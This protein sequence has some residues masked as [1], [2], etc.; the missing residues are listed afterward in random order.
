MQAGTTNLRK[1]AKP[2]LFLTTHL[3]VG[4]LRVGADARIEF[5]KFLCQ[6]SARI[7]Q[8]AVKQMRRVPKR[9]KMMMMTVARLNFAASGG[10]GGGGGRA[11]A[12]NKA[13]SA[14]ELTRS[15]VTL[16][17]CEQLAVSLSQ[18]LKNSRTFCC[19]AAAKEL[20]AGPV[21]TTAS[22]K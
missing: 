14:C 4:G 19:F 22:T 15:T 12:N 17:A 6:R 1:Q 16:S 2:P 20:L 10:G 13:T 5:L 7:T 9:T 21:T 11:G 3:V 18:P 8:V